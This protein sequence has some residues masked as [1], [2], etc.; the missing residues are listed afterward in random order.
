MPAPPAASPAG[1]VAAPRTDREVDK[2]STN[3]A[4][5]R[6]VMTSADIRACALFVRRSPASAAR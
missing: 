1:D 6:Q 2:S 4:P 3:L 5:G